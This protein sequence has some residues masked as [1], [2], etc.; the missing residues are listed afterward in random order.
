MAT[1]YSYSRR[2]RPSGA[3][4]SQENGKMKLQRIANVLAK[5]IANPAS[6]HNPDPDPANIL[7]V[8]DPGLGKT[9]IVEHACAIPGPYS[10]TT[11][12]G[13]HLITSHPVNS[14]PTDAKGMPTISECRTFADFV[15]FGDLRQAMAA[16]ERTVW[17]F[18]DLGTAPASVQASIMQL[19]LG[20]KINGHSLPSCVSFMAATNYRKAGMG[21]TGMLDP[22]K[23]RFL[24]IIEVE[25]D[26]DGWAAW[27]QSANL[28][29]M[30]TAYIRFD[31]VALMP[32]QL[33]QDGDAGATAGVST[34]MENSPNPRTW[35][36]VSRI[37]CWDLPEAD[38]RELIRGA[39]GPVYGRQFSEFK[40]QFGHIAPADEILENPDAFDIANAAPEVLHITCVTVAQRTTMENFPNVCRFSERLESEGFGEFASFLIRDTTRRQDALRATPAYQALLNSPVG[41]IITGDLIS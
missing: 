36:N 28:Q 41:A 2:D 16:T 35:E 32:S 18:D 21:V 8:G 3:I 23:G 1:L 39:V 14:D 4:A 31:G 13:A 26:V 29:P 6:P 38:E 27:A 24:T 34:G 17:F 37:L 22:V 40:K 20:G 9:K 7:L 30:V 15:P 25:A 33:G 10:G 5:A 12:P 11:L 19:L